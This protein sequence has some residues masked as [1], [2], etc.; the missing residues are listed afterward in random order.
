ME[1]VQ[2]LRD[3]AVEPTD[4]VLHVCLGGS[5]PAYEAFMAAMKEASVE[6]EWRYYQDV[7]AWLGKGV[8]RWVGPRGGQKEATVFWLSV[9]EGFFRLTFNVPMKSFSAVKELALS[10]SA[11]AILE[12]SYRPGYK[13][14]TAMFD[15]AD[16]SLLGD[17]RTLIEFRKLVR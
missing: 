17:V 7:R 13:N 4:E 1:S 12:A 5:F 8:Y 6:V 15:M 3:A 14:V 11:R 9:W 2:Q 10:A 16:E